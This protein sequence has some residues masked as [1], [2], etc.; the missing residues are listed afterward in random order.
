MVRPI[1]ADIV[2][3]GAEDAW[4]KEFS[5][6]DGTSFLRVD[7]AGW[8]PARCGKCRRFSAAFS[9]ALVS[10]FSACLSFSQHHDR[11]KF[12]FFPFFFFFFFLFV[13]L[14]QHPCILVSSPPLLA[15]A[16]E[17]T[18]PPEPR[19]CYPAARYIFVVLV[20]MRRA[21]FSPLVTLPY[22]LVH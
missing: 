19:Q 16:T 13:F 10:R 8:N 14:P 5:G 12:F 1:K 7:G 11:Y 22:K 3:A 9:P 2:V 6:T 15:D 18:S 20:L 21:A 4:R 17:H